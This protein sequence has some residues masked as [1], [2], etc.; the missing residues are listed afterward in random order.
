MTDTKDLHNVHH[1]GR[2]EI[3]SLIAKGPM[4]AVYRG[5]E[6]ERLVAV[7]LV[8]RG[9]VPEARLEELRTAAGVM[10]RMRHPAIVPFLELID[11]DRTIGLVSEFAVGE[12][13]AA[14]LKA[15]EY[16]DLKL[17]WEIMHQVLEA[18][19]AAHAV[20]M[21]HGNLK[22]ANIFIDREGHVSVSD[23]GIAGLTGTDGGTVEFMAPEQISDGV[24]DA[25]TDIYQAGGLA[26]LLVTRRMPFDGTREE[27]THRVLQERPTD[28]SQYVPKLAWQ[29]DWVIQR[30]LS[31]DPNDRF[32]GPR[33]FLDGLRLGLQESIGA[34]LPLAPKRIAPVTM[35]VHEKPKEPPPAPPP[36]PPPPKE[37]LAAKAKVIAKAP[38]AS[39]PPA[40]AAPP[41][42]PK[43]RLLLVDDDER[44]LNA[45]RMLFRDTYEV[46]TASG[47][48]PALQLMKTFAPHIVVSDQ[49]MPGMAGVELLREVRKLMPR[50][51]RILLT[52][53]SDLAAMVGSINEGEVFRF[54][55]K[56]WDNDEIKATLAE[57]AALISKIVPPVEKPIAP[58]SAGSLLVIDTD[59]ALGNGL[60]RLIAGEATVYEAR[61]AAEAAKIL[62]T[63]DVAAV[64]AD[65]RAGAS[66]LVS[67]FKLLKAKRPDTLSILLSDQPDSEVVSEMINQAHVHRFLSKPVN[68]RELRGHVADALRRYAAVKQAKQA[69]QPANGSTGL[70]DGIAAKPGLVSSAA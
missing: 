31:K 30:A 25:R 61:N 6:G 58:R 69:R 63:H 62:Q 19:E 9:S 1:V 51:V 60:K 38:V 12:P 41:P 68:A 65:M 8:H 16:P 4:G 20:S 40:P 46:E 53:Y 5:R 29:L 11:H 45:L 32:Q 42:P 26:Y 56:P 34:P 49:R 18:L 48:E 21:H 47:G 22:P 24:T 15:N 55:K 23:F 57:A 2:Y 67:L 66:G 13:L 59:P 44:V 14:R 10:T 28:P 7:K 52:G 33:E 43:I 50:T 35:P 70:A 39:P 17:V 54:V 3:G 37:S 64:V 36:P 27:V